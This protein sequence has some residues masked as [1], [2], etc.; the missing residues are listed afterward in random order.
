M[1]CL[2]EVEFSSVK[3]LINECYKTLKGDYYKIEENIKRVLFIYYPN[4]NL[5]DYIDDEMLEVF[6]K[7]FGKCRVKADNINFNIS[8]KSRRRKYFV[9]V[10]GLLDVVSGKEKMSVVDKSCSFLAKEG[11]PVV[12]CTHIIGGGDHE[13][14][15]RK[16]FKIGPLTHLD[17]ITVKAVKDSCMKVEGIEYLKGSSDWTIGNK[18]LY[19]Y[20]CSSPLVKKNDK[21]MVKK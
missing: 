1:R 2:N 8:Y 6:S 21:E 3:E 14:V 5:D 15:M 12:L 16:E 9:R 4:I 11:D 10:S 13:E 7:N 18:T 19:L 17:F 20:D